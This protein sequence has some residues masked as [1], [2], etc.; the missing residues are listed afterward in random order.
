M[1]H[2][3]VAQDPPRNVLWVELIMR[4][5]GDGYKQA[6][7]S[8]GTS[9]PHSLALAKAM[10]VKPATVVRLPSWTNMLK[11]RKTRSS[12]SP[13]ARGTALSTR[14]GIKLPGAT[15]IPLVMGSSGRAVAGLGVL[16]GGVDGGRAL[17]PS[18]SAGG[19]SRVE[20]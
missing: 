4:P 15:A 13:A 20:G 12:C 18:R 2:V 9:A 11:G 17:E 7:Q 14:T 8:S 19:S 10:L 5:D 3:E 1:D 6:M 16:L